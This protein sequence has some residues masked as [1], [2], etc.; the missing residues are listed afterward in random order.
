[1]N[2][3]AGSVANDLSGNGN[4]GTYNGTYTL[5]QTGALSGSG[6][7]STS[8]FLDGSTGYASVPYTATLNPAAFTVE[9]WVKP[10]GGAGTTRYVVGSGATN[11]GYNIY[12]ST[13]DVWKA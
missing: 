5:G 1:M 2:D 7:S 6:D 11:Y 9:A 4:N 12:A 8:T 3:S 13:G 10:T